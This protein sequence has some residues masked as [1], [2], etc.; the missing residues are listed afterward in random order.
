MIQSARVYEERF[1]L[2]GAFH[3]SMFSFLLGIPILVISFPNTLH[4]IDIV[5]L[6]EI[7]HLIELLLHVGMFMVEALPAV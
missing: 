3:E 7:S 6:K 5:S 4:K 1:G 2:R